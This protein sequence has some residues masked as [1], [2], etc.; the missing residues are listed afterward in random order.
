MKKKLQL[1]LDCLT[2]IYDPIDI[3]RRKSKFY[4]IYEMFDVT[5]PLLDDM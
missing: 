4:H 3:Q 2:S 1:L 5:S